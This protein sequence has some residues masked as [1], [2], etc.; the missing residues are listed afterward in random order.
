MTPSLVLPT[1]GPPFQQ[2]TFPDAAFTLYLETPG[3]GLVEN[4]SIQWILD[5]QLVLVG[6]LML[7]SKP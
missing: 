2:P 5:V 3:H 1:L 6:Q 4:P 7:S